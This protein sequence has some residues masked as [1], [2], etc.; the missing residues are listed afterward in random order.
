MLTVRRDFLALLIAALVILLV[1]SGCTS[2]NRGEETTLYSPLDATLGS[3]LA[4]PTATLPPLV[5]QDGAGGVVGRV[6][7]FP[8]DWAGLELT[9]Y[10][11]RFVSGAREDEGF[12]VLE[13]S[14]HPSTRVDD[15]GRFQIGTISPGRYVLVVGP[16]PQD[17][18]AISRNNRPL[19]VEITAGR[20][21]D[22]GEIY[23]SD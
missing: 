13:P 14:V 16:T 8:P 6:V 1:L 21:L 23:L 18:I 11:A 17:S 19:V 5:L 12:F 9:V 4:A 20:V 15:Y 3:P 10:F 2:D 22:L 7:S